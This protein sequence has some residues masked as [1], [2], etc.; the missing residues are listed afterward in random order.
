M[1]LN[2]IQL[3]SSLLTEMY[4]NSLVEITENGNVRQDSRSDLT[5]RPNDG[6]SATEWKYLGE[7]RK[8]ILLVA[9]YDL[10]THIP[11]EQLNFLIS[12]LGACKLSLAD[13][14]IVNIAGAPSPEYKT[15]QERFPSS[16]TILFGLS[17]QEFRMPVDFP[18]FQIQSFNS[19]TFL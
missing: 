3:N 13:V 16:F 12:I 8:N 10:V 15:V 18:Q 5:Q 9:R 1:S 17:P 2:N 6:V 19:C 14:A 4:R 7:F 11:D